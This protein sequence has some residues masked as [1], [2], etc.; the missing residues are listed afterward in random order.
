MVLQNLICFLLFLVLLHL[1]N[2]VCIECFELFPYIFLKSFVCFLG[3]SQ[4][5]CQDPVGVPGRQKQGDILGVPLR[6]RSNS[7]GLVLGGTELLPACAFSCKAFWL[8]QKDL[9]TARA[10][11]QLQTGTKPP[12]RTN[13]QTK[14]K[15]SPW[16]SI[17]F[18]PTVI[19]ALDTPL[20]LYLRH[21]NS[22][23]ECFS[24]L[25]LFL[26]CLCINY[27]LF[28]PLLGKLEAPKNAAWASMFK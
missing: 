10:E 7:A 24:P 2:V 5:P 25:I 21:S 9:H 19:R 28:L 22:F 15:S 11:F 8:Q 14:P 13:K 23:G 18:V 4:L 12:T 27:T 17:C 20:K 3:V 16:K 26:A 1:K 6:V